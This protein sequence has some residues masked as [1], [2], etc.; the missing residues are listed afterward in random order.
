MVS[1]DEAHDLLSLRQG[2][3]KLNIDTRPTLYVIM[4]D[5]EGLLQKEYEKR[6]D[7]EVGDLWNLADLRRLLG[8]Q[9][10]VMGPGWDALASLEEKAVLSLLEIMKRE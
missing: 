5:Y 9:S 7:F 1:I 3:E 10:L 4:R 6:V 2:L 8:R